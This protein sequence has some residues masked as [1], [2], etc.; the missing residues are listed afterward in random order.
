[1][2]N[3]SRYRIAA[4]VTAA[5]V[6]AGTTPAFAG[7]KLTNS[8]ARC[9]GA[10]PSVLVTIEGVKN[11]TGTVRVQLYR[12]TAA[13]WMEKGKWLNRIDVP[14]RAG[15]MKVCMPAPAAGNYGIAVRH[16]ANGNG[17]TDLTKDGGG[18]SNNP[19]INIF[20]L[21]KPSYT[22]TRIAVGNAVKPITIKMKYM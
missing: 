7:Q 22:K 8:M 15:T 6:L 5:L 17:D 1:M 11:S 21:G 16:D 14:A 12:S 4:G 19:S 10:K 20:N 18:M 9:Q 13:E 3:F 2:F